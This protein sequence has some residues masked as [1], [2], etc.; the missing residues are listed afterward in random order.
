[1]GLMGCTRECYFGN[2][3]VTESKSATHNFTADLLLHLPCTDTALFLLGY[4]D[5]VVKI[6]ATLSHIPHMAEAEFIEKSNK[7]TADCSKLIIPRIFPNCTPVTPESQSKK[8][9]REEG[10]D[11][12]DQQSQVLPPDY[13]AMS[14]ES[15]DEKLMELR[16]AKKTAT[17]KVSK[18]KKDLAAKN[19]AQKKKDDLAMRTAGNALQP[20]ATSSAAKPR[21]PS[22]LRK[23]PKSPA[24]KLA[25]ELA[26]LPGFE[27]EEEMEES[28]E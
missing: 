17:K 13:A 23:P 18:D 1:M 4:T 2:I 28:E 9:P 8:R 11:D 27:E 6:R 20:T 26:K 12:S 19:A 22:G 14:M 15:L 25:A 10:D 7:A 5:S 3:L 16:E 24:E 21:A